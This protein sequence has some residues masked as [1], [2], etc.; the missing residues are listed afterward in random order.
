MVLDLR[1]RYHVSMLVQKILAK[2]R[3]L[4]LINVNQRDCSI[5]FEHVVRLS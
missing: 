3:L 4:L 5:V 2:S 1:K